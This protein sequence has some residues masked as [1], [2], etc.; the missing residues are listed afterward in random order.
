VS[1]RTYLVHD[2]CIILAALVLPIAVPDS[3]D[4]KI[5][6]LHDGFLRMSY[7]LA[8]FTEPSFDVCQRLAFDGADGRIRLD[9]HLRGS[10]LA[11]RS[12]RTRSEER[13][14]STELGCLGLAG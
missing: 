4:R 1:R 14:A 13:F 8:L 7:H 10:R 11:S 12:L 3:V 9:R 5:W 6:P 2:P